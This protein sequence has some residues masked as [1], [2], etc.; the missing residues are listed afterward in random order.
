[1]VTLDEQVD[2]AGLTGKRVLDQRAMRVLRK[3]R[4]EWELD[5][6]RLTAARSLTDEQRAVLRPAV[7]QWD[8]RGSVAWS[9]RLKYLEWSGFA[10]A[11][12]V[13]LLVPPAVVILFVPAAKALTPA[14]VLLAAATYLSIYGVLSAGFFMW[15]G[16]SRLLLVRESQLLG[17]LVKLGWLAAAVFIVAAVVAVVVGSADWRAMRF[18]FAA[19]LVAAVL[20]V[21]AQWSGVGFGSYMWGPWRSRML[22]TL[23]SSTVVASRLW[24]LVDA[25][26]KDHS[27]WTQF[28][29]RRDLMARISFASNWLERRMPRMMWFAGYRGPAHAEA[30]RRYRRAA[31]FTRSF[32]WRVMDAADRSDFECIRQDLVDASVAMAGGDWTPLPEVEEPTGTSKAFAVGRRLITPVALG[33]AALL[34]PY[35]PGLSST[36]PAVTALQVALFVAA[37]LSLT[38]VDEASRERILGA[39]GGAHR[40]S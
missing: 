30:V 14:D 24:F 32:A 28:A 38:P 7:R 9:S 3:A 25:F 17:R 29:T 37:V 23:P 1:M 33:A 13:V 27:T 11:C 8:A 15:F 39:L 34:L 5:S 40:G 36:G 18:G 20:M 26:E 19:G 22:G 16:I 6:G 21:V 35:V 10:L 2:S 31:G 4:T 12:A